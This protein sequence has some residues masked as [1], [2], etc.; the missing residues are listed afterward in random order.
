MLAHE[1]VEVVDPRARAQRL[2]G[3][4]PRRVPLVFGHPDVVLQLV[5]EGR[6]C[7]LLDLRIEDAVDA[8]IVALLAIEVAVH[9]FG[10]ERVD[11]VVLF[12]ACDDDV[13]VELGAKARDPLHQ[14][15]RGHLGLRP[16]AVLQRIERVVD[17]HGLQVA[18]ALDR[19][20]RILRGRHAGE[21][22]AEGIVERTRGGVQAFDELAQLERFV[23]DDQ[24]PADRFSHR[25]PY[26]PRQWP[27]QRLPSS[28]SWDRRRMASRSGP[29]TGPS[30]CAG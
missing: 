24:D 27:N 10:E 6:A 4:M 15:E 1:L 13:D 16:R 30:A 21:A 18:V 19:G 9:R 17:E 22:D 7:P 12:L 2:A 3:G 23:V 5:E 11:D 14:L 26:N 20:E 28:S 8:A 29:A 25:G